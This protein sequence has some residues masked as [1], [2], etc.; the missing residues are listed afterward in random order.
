M[1]ATRGRTLAEFGQAFTP[2]FVAS[3]PRVPPH[4]PVGRRSS[5]YIDWDKLL[6]DILEQ[7]QLITDDEDILLLIHSRVF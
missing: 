3:R 1:A 4:P 6:P 5:D 7:E 2:I